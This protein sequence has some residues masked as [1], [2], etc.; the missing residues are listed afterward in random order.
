MD[1][2]SRLHDKVDRIEIKIDTIVDQLSNQNTRLEVYNVELT[3]H[4]EGVELARSETAML[5]EALDQRTA[6]LEA[7]IKPIKKRFEAIST[8]KSFLIK[9]AMFVAGVLGAISAYKSLK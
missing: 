6:A 9:T 5:R 2:V 4:I 7:S 1:D 8:I 3:K